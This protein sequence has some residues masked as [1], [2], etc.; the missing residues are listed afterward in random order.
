MATASPKLKAT[1]VAALATEQS[2]QKGQQYFRNGAIRNPVRQGNTLWA[3][4]HGM[5]VYHPKATLSKQGVASSSC[6]CPYDWG[7]ICKHQVALLLTYIHEPDQFQVLQPLKQLLAKRSRED[8]LQMMEQMVQRHPDLMSVIDAPQTPTAGQ[9]PDFV[10]YQRQVE[11]VFQDD[12]MHSMADGLEALAEH[13]QSLSNNGD[14]LNAG[15]VYQL[16]LEAANT[17]YDFS[18][19]EIDYNGEVGCVIQEIAEGLSDCLK[20]ATNLD[21][22]QRLRWVETLFNAVLKDIELGGMDYAYPAG[23]AIVNLTTTDDWTWLEPKIRKAIEQVGQRSSDWRRHQLV[24]LLAAGTHHRESAQTADDI[25]LELG[26]PEQRAFFHL[27]QGNLEEAVAIA[28]AHFQSLPGLVT[29]FADALIEAKAPDLALKFIQGS[30]QGGRHS[31]QDWLAKFYQQYGTTEQFLDA[32]L[33]LLKTRFTLQ[34]YQTLQAKAEPLKRW[35][36]LRQSLHKA[37]VEKERYSWLMEIALWEQDWKSAKR[38]LKK[39]TPWDQLTWKEQVADKIKTDEPETAISFYQD[40][41]EYAINLRG[42]DNYRRAVQYLKTIQP[43]YQQLKQDK[44][45][46]QYVQ[47]VRTQHKNLPALKQELDKVGF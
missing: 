35:K 47:E 46:Q 23:D 4:C 13:G 29:Q 30:A 19:L 32:Q 3:D 28:H 15:N 11:R 31:Y 17:H 9:L 1:Q 16:L 25:I 12:E 42:R 7:G 14:W 40:L 38:Y 20:Q 8:L 33:E 6:T 41:V 27:K 22:E 36:S 21:T 26:T 45:F 34:G 43:L 44:A 10:K 18:V 5:N 2:F 37:F 24:N 39:M